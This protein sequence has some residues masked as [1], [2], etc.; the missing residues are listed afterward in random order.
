[1]N[2]LYA[3]PGLMTPPVAPKSEHRLTSDPYGVVRGTVY[4]SSR[5]SDHVNVQVV[6]LKPGG[7]YE[8]LVND[9]GGTT[10][11]RE[12]VAANPERWDYVWYYDGLSTP[13]PAGDLQV[14]IDAP[15]A[16]R[17]IY[18]LNVQDVVV[19]EAV[20]PVEEEVETTTVESVWGN[21]DLPTGVAVLYI[22]FD[23]VFHTPPTSILISVVAPS[24]L[25][26][27]E[28]VTANVAGYTM[29]GLTVALTSPVS[30]EGYKIAWSATTAPTGTQTPS[31]QSG[32]FLV[33]AGATGAVIPLRVTA[34]SVPTII[35]T[36]QSVS[37][38]QSVEVVGFTIV[39]VT[40]TNF[41]VLFSS[42]Q[43]YPFFFNWLSRT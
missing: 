22:P 32:Q 3:I 41:T 23:F 25:S 37:H 9:C 29:E 40:T 35:G 21:Y 8:R 16:S 13:L 24:G 1:M 20:V 36:V 17:V 6:R 26:S 30:I 27:V 11:F 15:K 33:E 19:D 2:N 7:R 14:W 5:G 34:P 10:L 4:R 18:S 43:V 39:G 12:R 42:P 31:N 38:N 28:V